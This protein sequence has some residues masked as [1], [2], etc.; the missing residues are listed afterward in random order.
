MGKFASVQEA[1]PV[2]PYSEGNVRGYAFSPLYSSV[3]K[4]AAVDIALYEMLALV[5][6]IRDGRA[7]EAG[8]AATEIQARLCGK[9]HR[10]AC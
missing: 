3:P 4:A 8:M 7:R 9:E 2:W 1:P 5:D 10:K 6:A